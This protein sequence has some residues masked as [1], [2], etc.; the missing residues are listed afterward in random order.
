MSAIAKAWSF[1]SDTEPEKDY[2]TLLR[3][4]GTSS[5]ECRGWTMKR[6]NQPRSCKHTRWIDL[7]IADQRCKSVVDYRTGQNKK[8]V[9]AM[10]VPL[11]Q[12]STP[13]A[14]VAQR[15]RAIRYD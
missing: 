12:E 14:R 4:D 11:H 3:M 7:G 15:E 10:L 9:A 13:V 5:C 2:Q 6:K 8:R 1:P